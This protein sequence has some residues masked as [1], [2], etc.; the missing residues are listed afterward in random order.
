MSTSAVPG[1]LRPAPDSMW[2][3]SQRSSVNPRLHLLNYLWSLWAL[4]TVFFTDVPVSFWWSLGISYAVFTLLFVLVHVRP[5]GEMHAYAG[6]IALVALVSMFWNPSGWTFG[7]FA[8][9]YTGMASAE[10]PRAGVFRVAM[11]EAGMLALGWWLD[12]PWFA[13]LI[14]ASV[15]TSAGLGAMYGHISQLRGL[16][17]RRSHEEVRRL[18]ATAERERIGRDLHDLLGHT[19]S[20][21]TLKL[22]LSRKLFDRD[23]EAARRE[24]EDAERVAR[25]ALAEVRSAVTGIRATDLAAELASA[26]LLLESSGVAVACDYPRQGVPEAVERVAAL[27]VR[28]AA[29]NI[30]RHANAS[31]A[32]IDVACRGDEVIVRITDNGRGGIRSDGNGLT[33][34]RER[35]HAVGGVL[36]IDSVRGKGTALTMNIPVPTAAA[37]PAPDATGTASGMDDTGLPRLAGHSA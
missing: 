24:L 36:A 15:C 19:L 9:V 8:C 28:E 31:R 13:L 25:H 2:R 7:V 10:S 21:I 14:A 16:E 4:A 3:Q 5:R 37:A 34:M 27:A 26:R 33:G 35:L 32:S 29:T 11:I 1:W 22:E 6:L 17:M 20:L 12:W 30:A 18:A 23:H